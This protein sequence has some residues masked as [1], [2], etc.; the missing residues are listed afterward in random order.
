MMYPVSKNK[1]GIRSATCTKREGILKTRVNMG[2]TP[3]TSRQHL[4]LQAPTLI[5]IK[6]RTIGYFLRRVK[7]FDIAKETRM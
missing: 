3:L 5:T 2:P 6:L 1:V 4:T 7:Y